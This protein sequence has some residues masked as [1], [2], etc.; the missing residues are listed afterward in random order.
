VLYELEVGGVLELERGGVLDPDAVLGTVRVRDGRSARKRA[1]S[2]ARDIGAAGVFRDWRI[3]AHAD[4]LAVLGAEIASSP[5]GVSPEVLAS[6]R[7]ELERLLAEAG[8]LDAARARA[9]LDVL[10]R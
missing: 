2:P 1:E 4:Q 10:P 6:L 3:N 7:A 9:L 8:E 5:A